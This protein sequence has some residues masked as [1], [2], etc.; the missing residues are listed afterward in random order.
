MGRKIKRLYGRVQAGIKLLLPIDWRA[1]LLSIVLICVLAEVT[2]D[3]AI[4]HAKEP[5]VV[6]ELGMIWIQSTKP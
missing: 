4:R 1:V 6:C 3:G 5:L 2:G